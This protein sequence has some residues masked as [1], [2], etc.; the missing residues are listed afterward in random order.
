MNKKDNIQWGFIS[1]VAF[2]C[3]KKTFITILLYV[4]MTTMTMKILFACGLVFLLSLSSVSTDH[5]ICFLGSEELYYSRR[6][7]NTSS[8]L[9]GTDYWSY[10]TR[11]SLPYLKRCQRNCEEAVEN[12]TTIIYEDESKQYMDL[13]SPLLEMDEYISL[14]QLLCRENPDVHKVFSNK[15]FIVRVHS[16]LGCT[17]KDRNTGI[18]WPV[19]KYIPTNIFSLT[20]LKCKD[21]VFNNE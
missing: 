1:E 7:L 8:L 10:Q 2:L 19:I 17:R 14:G 5:C 20:T 12:R 3:L 21:G 4:K 9:N 11:C 16:I 18:I 6:Q 13:R 15:P